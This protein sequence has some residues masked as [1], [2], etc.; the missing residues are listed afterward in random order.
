MLQ[1]PH[2]LVS[3]NVE[4]PAALSANRHVNLAADDI[5]VSGMV[6]KSNHAKSAASVETSISCHC[7]DQLSNKE[8]EWIC[9][10]RMEGRHL[11]LTPFEPACITQAPLMG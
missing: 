11:G 10:I 4:I 7:C 2:T 6:D 1:S 5:G 9:V 8:R 3:V